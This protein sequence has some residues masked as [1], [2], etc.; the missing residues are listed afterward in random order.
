MSSKM[1]L[2]SKMFD[3]RSDKVSRKRADKVGNKALM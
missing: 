3:N 1:N 2:N